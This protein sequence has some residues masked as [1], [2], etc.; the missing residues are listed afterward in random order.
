MLAT[1]MV[2]C[3]SFALFFVYTL[4]ISRVMDEYNTFSL[5]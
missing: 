4:S 3:S 2:V 5:K 1:N